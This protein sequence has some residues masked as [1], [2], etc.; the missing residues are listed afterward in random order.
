MQNLEQKRILDI[1]N[2]NTDSEI[3]IVYDALSN[4]DDILELLEKHEYLKRVRLKPL[5]GI[6]AKVVADE[7]K[8]GNYRKIFGMYTSSVC[9]KNAIEF[10]QEGVIPIVSSLPDKDCN[11]IDNIASMFGDIIKPNTPEKRIKDEDD[12]KINR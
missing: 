1:I 5:N 9:M 11:Y 8:S 12:I 3:T 6:N 4:I 2:Q 10:I 7:F